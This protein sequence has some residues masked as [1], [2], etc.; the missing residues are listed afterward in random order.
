MSEIEMN[1]PVSLWICAM[2]RRDFVMEKD[3][4]LPDVRIAR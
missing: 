4:E 2:L 3:A 1:L